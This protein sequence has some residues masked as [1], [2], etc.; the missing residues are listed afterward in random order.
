MQYSEYALGRLAERCLTKAEVE[1]VIANPSRGI[2]EPRGRDRREHFGY[3]ADGRRL[4]VVTDR[5][6]S[7]VISVIEQ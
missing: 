4:N 3:A 5:A 6:V 2:Y 1:G 7:V